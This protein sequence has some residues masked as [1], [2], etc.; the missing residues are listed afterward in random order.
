ML[1]GSFFLEIQKQFKDIARDLDIEPEIIR[2]LEEPHRIAKFQIP[3]LMDDGKM[4]FF[5]GF[6]A[7]HNNILGPHKGGIRYS[8]DVS[9]D[10][11]KALS[12]LMTWKCSLVG[13]PLGGA[14]GG[15]IVD[16]RKLSR[17]ELERLSR[18]Y[19][20]EAFPFIGPEIDIPAPD[21]NTN[22]QI[23]AWMVDEYSK[24]KGKDTPASFTGKPTELLGLSGREEATGYGGIV[25]LEKLRKIFGFKPENTTLAIQGF[26]NVGSHF[27]HFAFKKGYRIIAISEH[28]GGIQVEKGLNPQKTLECK[29]KNGK[30]AGC[31]CIGSVCDLKFGKTV[32][33]KELLRMEVDVLVPAA[34][35][36][37]ITEENVSEIKAKY[38]I[39]MANGPVT[40]KA[41]DLLHKR[42]IISV[43]DILANAGG[44][45]A[46]YFE[47][48][49]SKEKKK[50]EKEKTFD[51]L[52]T[53]L[54]KAFDKVW[55]LSKK[56]NICPREAAYR[57]A[58][59][60]VVMAIKNSRKA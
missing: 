52:S 42:N 18:G 33:N 6:R 48:L 56:E 19:V 16:P 54:E 55:R 8:L 51:E 35:E 53:I 34:V 36:D 17:T 20:R 58:I 5:T 30:I 27:A 4:N 12:M 38:I 7:Q 40:P 2:E 29:D 25:I 32:T 24:L 23:M 43:P 31:Y 9:E 60:R 59:D 13:L 37:V 28:E 50:W 21:I 14:K 49:Q 47:W 11:V 22:S 46:S 39:E 3:V 10:E 26:G 15:V 41:E 1:K 45:I 44:V 57:I